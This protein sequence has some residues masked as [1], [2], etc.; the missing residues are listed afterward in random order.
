[1][2]TTDE[3]F[4]AVPDHW[5]AATGAQLERGLGT[6]L[7]VLHDARVV[8][9]VALHYDRDS[10]YAGA[11]FLDIDPVDPYAITSGDLLSLTL[12]GVKAEPQAVRRLLEMT[13]TNREIRGLLTEEHLPLDADLMVADNDTLVAMASLH[14]TLKRALSLDRTQNKNP[15]VTAAKLCARKRPDLFP[16]RDTVVCDLLGLRVTRHNY[17][18]DWQVYRH[19]IQNDEVRTRLDE[20]ID[21]VQTRDGVN[22]GH[23]NRRLRHLDVALWMHGRRS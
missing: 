4:T 16:V 9:N 2:T 13:A 8:D 19:I 5:K 15:W 11:T 1:M 12:L 10:N 3:R 20:I 6:A 18:V 14:E 7:S 17:E 21:E 22:V 23:V